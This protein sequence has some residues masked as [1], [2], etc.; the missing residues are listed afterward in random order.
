MVEEERDW[1][2]VWRYCFNSVRTTWGRF[3]LGREGGWVSVLCLKSRFM[4]LCSCK[5]KCP[6]GYCINGSIVQEGHSLG[7]T[8]EGVIRVLVIGKDAFPVTHTTCS[9][10]EKNSWR[11]NSV[12]LASGCPT[13]MVSTLFWVCDDVLFESWEEKRL[14]T[15][16]V[17]QAGPVSGSEVA[18]FLL[19]WLVSRAR[20]ALFWDLPFGWSRKAEGR[21]LRRPPA[22]WLPVLLESSCPAIVDEGVG[23][24]F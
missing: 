9:L 18:V 21:S 4:H 15:C 11:H 10:V 20:S 23:M 16:C 7:N 6:V 19:L 3:D 5:R 13:C 2:G 22:G 14:L 17:A 1:L 12:G 8:D 24:R